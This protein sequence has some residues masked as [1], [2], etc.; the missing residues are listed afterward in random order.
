MTPVRRPG[1][2]RILLVLLLTAAAPAAGQGSPAAVPRVEGE[3]L[4][5]PLLPPGHWAVRAAERADRMGLL[6]RWLPAQ[7]AVPRRV[8]GAALA[9]AADAADG[10]A[11]KYRI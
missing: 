1:R 4:V 5:S 2:L 8:V 11:L 10:S 6:R 7:N 3:V 9:E